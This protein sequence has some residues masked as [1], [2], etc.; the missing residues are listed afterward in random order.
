MS[1]AKRNILIDFDSLTMTLFFL[2]Y[3]C[4]ILITDDES[5]SQPSNEGGI[6][7]TRGVEVKL[8]LPAFQIRGPNME[9]VKM[10]G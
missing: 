5:R 2:C 7:N 4:E 6:F 10:M 3:C 1:N 9:A 8:N